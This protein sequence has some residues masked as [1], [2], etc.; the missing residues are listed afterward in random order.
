MTKAKRTRTRSPCYFPIRI[1]S[2]KRLHAIRHILTFL[3]LTFDFQWLLIHWIVDEIEL[4]I[5]TRS[6]SLSEKC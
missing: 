5:H 2:M 4:R 1:G 3:D 6:E